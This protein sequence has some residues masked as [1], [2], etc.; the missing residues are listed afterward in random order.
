MTEDKEGTKLGPQLDGF[1]LFDFI[2]LSY[3]ISFPDNDFIPPIHLVTSI[4]LV[5]CFSEI[6]KILS[7]LVV[8]DWQQ[9]ASS[10]LISLG[11]RFPK[12]IT[13]QCLALFGPGVVPHYFVMKTIGDLVLHLLS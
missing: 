12:K 6:S 1:P 8:P 7:V 5:K 11:M 2:Y 10:V 3:G 9:K 4:H 13:E